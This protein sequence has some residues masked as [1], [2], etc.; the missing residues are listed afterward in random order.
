MCNAISSI[1]LNCC[2]HMCNA[3]SSIT[4]NSCNYSCNLK[5]CGPWIAG[6]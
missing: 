1:K 2:N 3:N 5:K 4:L 6:T